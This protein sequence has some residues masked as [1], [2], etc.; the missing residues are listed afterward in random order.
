MVMCRVYLIV[1]LFQKSYALTDAGRF[2]ADLVSVTM[3]L[4]VKENLN[5]LIP[6]RNC[7]KNLADIGMVRTR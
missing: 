7:A 3:T 5:V 6:L 4:R 2:M 1:R